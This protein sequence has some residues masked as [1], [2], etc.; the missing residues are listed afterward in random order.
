MLRSL[1]IQGILLVGVV[2]FAGN[3]QKFASIKHPQSAKN[4]TNLTQGHKLRDDIQLQV[5]Y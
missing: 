2:S 4:G 5:I 1:K 3:L